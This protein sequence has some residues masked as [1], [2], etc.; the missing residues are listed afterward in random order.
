MDIFTFQKDRSNSNLGFL[1]NEAAITVAPKYDN[2][3]SFLYSQNRIDHQKF[4]NSSYYRRR[5]KLL[6][7]AYL[8]HT[9]LP[10]Y[11]VLNN[12]TEFWRAAKNRNIS[13]MSHE[14]MNRAQYVLN[15]G[16]G[17]TPDEVYQMIRK[18]IDLIWPFI[19]K[20]GSINLDDIFYIMSESEINMPEQ[21]KKLIKKVY[22]T[23]QGMFWEGEISSHR[24]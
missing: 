11:D 14:K 21:K 18:Q 20:T 6:E 22:D 1:V 3:Y 15:N 16:I 13:E 10:K 2:G 12:I 17:L 9:I 5:E 24:R 23:T 19:E 4:A 8:Y 7:N